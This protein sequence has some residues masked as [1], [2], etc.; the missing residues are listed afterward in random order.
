M[1]YKVIAKYSNKL[2]EDEWIKIK[3]S[4]N[5]IFKK[6]FR[7]E[8]FKKKYTQNPLGFSCHGILYN[9]NE[10]VGC[11]TIVPRN[12]FFK[13]KKK[14]I[15]VGCD[16]FI[17]KEHRIDPFLL[18]N[19]SESIF[20]KLSEYNIETFISLPTLSSPYKYWK[21]IGKWRDIGSLDYYIVPIN[22]SKILFKKSFLKNLSFALSYSLSFFSKIFY[23]PYTQIPSKDIHLDINKKNRFFLDSYKYINISHNNWACYRVVKEQNLKVAYLLYVNEKSKKNISLII[24]RMISMLGL[25]VD[26]IV[27]LGNLKYKPANLIKLPS[28]MHPR[29]ARFI[30]FSKNINSKKIY[31]LNKWD[32]SLAD[33]DMR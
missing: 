6:N 23:Q 2:N 20:K 33:F 7:I 21:I 1:S 22:I 25:K 5:F 12:Y 26:M 13:A 29:K 14:L 16:A 10:L 9:N 32:V 3:N 19:M 27:Y 15:G 28:F 24:F 30:A 17:L 18:K 31:D 11:F 4:F 8:Y